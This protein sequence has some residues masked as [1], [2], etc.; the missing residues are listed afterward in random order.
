MEA[1]N[2][3][4]LRRRERSLGSET[5]KVQGRQTTEYPS[6]LANRKLVTLVTTVR[7][8]GQNQELRVIME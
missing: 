6:V 7:A 1:K 2:K 5:A 3:R 4:P 8:E